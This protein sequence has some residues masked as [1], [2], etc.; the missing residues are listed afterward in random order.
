MIPTCFAYV[1]WDTKN[2]LNVVAGG[3]HRMG[4]DTQKLV[5]LSDP[6]AGYVNNPNMLCYLNQAADRLKVELQERMRKA[7]LRQV[8]MSYA[9]AK[10]I[11]NK[12][13][14][15]QPRSKLTKLRKIAKRIPWDMLGERGFKCVRK[16]NTLIFIKRESYP[17]GNKAPRLISFP[18][19]GEKLILTMAF[20]PVLHPLFSSRYAS[21]E[22]PEEF[23]PKVIENRL[24]MPGCRKFVA[25][26]TSWE[27]VPT[28]EIMQ[29]GEHRVLRG[30]I[31]ESYHFVFPWIEK[32]GVLRHKSGVK[33]KISAVQYSGRYTT[34][35]SNTIRN[36]LMMDAVALY[37]KTDYRGVFEGDDSLTTW[38]N[39]ITID[40]VQFALSRIGVVAE[41]A[42]VP[43]LGYGGYCSTYWNKD[44]EI[45]VE[46]VKC[47]CNFQVSRSALGATPKNIPMLL[48]AK[49][50]SL[51]YRAP[52]CPVIYALV[53]KYINEYGLLDSKNL[54]ERDR[55]KSFAK[56]V[57]DQSRTVGQGSVKV[58]F[59][60]WDLIREPTLKQRLMF[61]EIFHLNPHDQ[62]RVEELIM[63]EF[64]FSPLL[65]KI[66]TPCV[67]RNGLTL[68]ELMRNYQYM[69][70]NRPCFTRGTNFSQ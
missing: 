6:T 4:V 36:K 13:R 38:P 14:G 10:F 20:Y 51:A 58:R 31:P 37:Y 64:G 52:G 2:P 48:S 11:I 21:K 62:E 22:V 57:R 27:C 45:V 56:M 32:G 40:K 29:A 39:D 26:Y 55:T 47:L 70:R 24:T 34:S 7:D 30:L 18:Q 23:R 42:E 63:T 61:Y 50:M 60:R 28:K 44:K 17:A 69:I 5:Q 25:D 46:P 33:M 59:E 1:E 54:W 68:E 9:G 67:A 3:M 65:L 16:S 35:L 8:E 12:L 43:E 53:K 19:E 66:L 41:M 49:A 15:S